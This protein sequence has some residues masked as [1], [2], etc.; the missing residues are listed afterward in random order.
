MVGYLKGNDPSIKD[1]SIFFWPPPFF[2]G[3]NE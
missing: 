1:T 3:G 2:V